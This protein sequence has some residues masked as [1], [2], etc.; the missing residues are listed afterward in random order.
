VIVSNSKDYIWYASYGS[1]INSERFLCYIKGGSP[2]GSTRVEAGCRDR[3]LPIDESVF[4]INYPLYF[5]K[6]AKGWNAQGVAFIGLK[7]NP[8]TITYSKKYLVTK[9]QFLDIVKQENNGIEFDI[10]FEDVKKTGSKDFRQSWYGNILY[11]GEEEGY[12]IFTFTS[13]TDMDEVI[14]EKPSHEY[15]STIIKGLR[16]EYSNKVIYEYL[17]TKP[18]IK[19]YYSNEELESVIHSV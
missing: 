18:G 17:H 14:F 7:Q 2:K 3:S 1:N 19:N 16:V 9:E 4:I 11:L 8:S 5:A 13:P 15:L 10:N 12:P 6:R